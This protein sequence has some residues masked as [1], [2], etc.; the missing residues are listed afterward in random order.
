MSFEVK[1]TPEMAQKKAR[2]ATGLE[3]HGEGNGQGKN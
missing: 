1:F 2:L 3:N